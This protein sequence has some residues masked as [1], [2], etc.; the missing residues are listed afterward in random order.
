MVPKA[1]S[2]IPPD[3]STVSPENEPLDHRAELA[4][5][6]PGQVQVIRRNAEV[7][8]GEQRGR[9]QPHPRHRTDS[10]RPGRGCPHPPPARWQYR[11]H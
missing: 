1:P 8:R 6:I 5:H 7:T 11:A 10:H 2:V 3:L 4:V 9:F